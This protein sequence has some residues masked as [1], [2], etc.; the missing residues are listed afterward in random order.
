MD[1]PAAAISELVGG[2]VS[3]YLGSGPK[4][5]TYL[6]GDVVT[7][8]LEDTLTKGEQRLVRDGMSE[9]VLSTRRAFEHCM[10]ND[11][12]AGVEAITG[13]KVRACANQMAT[14]ITVEVLVL[15]R[16]CEAA[17]AESAQRPLTPAL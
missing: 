17:A 5:R 15:A 8:V 11:L 14:D 16:S 9:L 10:R 12:K 3:E 6:N 4:A 13:R 2:L 7:I 1:E